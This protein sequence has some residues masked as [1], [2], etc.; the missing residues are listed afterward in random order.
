LRFFYFLGYASYFISQHGQGIFWMVLATE[1]K[2]P[3]AS[4]KYVIMVAIISALSGLLFGYDTG[5]ISGAILLIKKQFVLSAAWQQAIIGAV[6]L[7]AVFGTAT[8]D[9]IGDKFGRKKTIIVSAFIFAFGGVVTALAPD[10][11]TLSI[12]RI[13]LGVAV[14]VASCIFPKL[15]RTVFAARWYFCFS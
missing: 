2:A 15:P 4:S 10:A 12:G 13:F 5:V 6:L 11:L 7:G 8:S 3:V 9:L 14:G 1:N